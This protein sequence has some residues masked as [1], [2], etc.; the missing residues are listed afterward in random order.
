MIELGTKLYLARFIFCQNIGK[1]RADDARFL[2]QIR[3]AFANS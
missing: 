3:M 1:I 2:A